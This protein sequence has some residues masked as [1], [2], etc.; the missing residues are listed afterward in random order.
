[1]QGGIVSVALSLALR[2]V[3]VTHCL[4]PREDFLWGYSD[5]PPRIKIGAGRPPLLL[6]LPKK[7]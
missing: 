1:V 2:P 5:F 7:L 4:L 6:L 3:G